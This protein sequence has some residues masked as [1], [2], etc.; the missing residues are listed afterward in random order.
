MG[1]WLLPV[2]FIEIAQVVHEIWCPQDLTSM[3]CGDYDL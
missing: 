3:A 1:Y 2:N